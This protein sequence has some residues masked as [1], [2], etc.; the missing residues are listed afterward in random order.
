MKASWY[1]VSVDNRNFKCRA[2]TLSE[3]VITFVI[4]S[5][6]FALSIVSLTIINP[7]KEGW[8]TLSRKTEIAIEQASTGIL[9]NNC[10]YD[11]Y[12]SLYDSLGKFSIEDQGVDARMTNLYKKYLQNVSVS[13]DLSNEYFLE[14]LKTAKGELSNI[15]L[16]DI[17]DNFFFIQDGVLIGFRFYNSCSATEK[18]AFPSDS[19]EVYEIKDVCGSIFYDVN[20]YKKPNKLGLD[21]H[22]IAIYERGIKYDEN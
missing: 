9:L 5:I 10:S 11:N 20:S 22:I 7:S 6:I 21:Q 3:M 8:L 4:I 14:N 15:P 18:W 17:Y 16:K 2:F 12:K 1:N 13:V 19:D